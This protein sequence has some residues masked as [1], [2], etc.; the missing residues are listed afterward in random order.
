MNAEMPGRSNTIRDVAQRAGVSI[1]TVSKAF[2]NRLD[3]SADTRSRVLAAAADLHYKPNALIR[4]LRRG[5]TRTVGIYATWGVHID[6]SRDI[7]GRVARG[8]A[9]GLA[10]TGYDALHYSSFKDRTPGNIAATFLDGRVDAVI[11]M[12]KSI[13]RQ[14]YVALVEQGLPT[15][16]L[17]DRTVPDGVA[18]VS[19]DNEQGVLDAM[20]HLFALGHRRIG[21]FAPYYTPDFDER[22]KSYRR[23]FERRGVP[24]DGTLMAYERESVLD[25]STACD[26]L[27]SLGDPVTAI[28]ASDDNVAMEIWAALR[29][30]KVRVPGQ[31]SLVGFDD[32]DAALSPHRLTTVRQPAM[33]VGRLAALFA[34]RMIDGT[35]ADECRVVLPVKLIVRKTTKK[36]GTFVPDR[37]ASATAKGARG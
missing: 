35:V 2:N 9:D 25:A 1:S 6:C 30:C 12:P 15:V 18:Y 14:G 32:V 31:I 8:L 3:L 34:A 21:F 28:M 5:S 36:I 4:S 37:A 17:Y 26:R 10:E 23:A 7:T 20:D 22:A 33:E 29:K 19:I 11:V 13:D 27:L 24:Y 16:A